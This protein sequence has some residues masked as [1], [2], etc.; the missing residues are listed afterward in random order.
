VQGPEREQ[1]QE[2]VP[3]QEQVQE[4]EQEHSLEQ[5]LAKSM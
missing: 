4:P 2:P 5:P 1:V 3:E